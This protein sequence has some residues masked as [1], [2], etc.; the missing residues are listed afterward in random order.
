MEA[1]S[2][3]VFE[4]DLTSVEAYEANLGTVVTVTLSAQSDKTVTAIATEPSI[5]TQMFDAGYGAKLRNRISVRASAFTDASATPMVSEERVTI[6]GRTFKVEGRAEPD[7]LLYHFNLV[8][9][10]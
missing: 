1:A 6:G 5:E 3:T 9:D 4:S 7:A 10:W 2:T 8:Q